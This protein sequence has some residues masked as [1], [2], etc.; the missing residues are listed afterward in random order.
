MCSP[1][2]TGWRRL[3]IA[4]VGG[5]IGGLA[6]AISLRRAG[7]SVTIYERADFAGEKG[8]SV[9]C[10]ANGT[11]WLEEWGVDVQKGDPVHLKK[12][13]SR[14]KKRLN[15]EVVGSVWDL[16]SWEAGELRGDTGDEVGVLDSNPLRRSSGPVVRLCLVDY[17][18]IGRLTTACLPTP[19]PTGNLPPSLAS[20]PSSPQPDEQTRY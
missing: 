6:A 3:N 16:V 13:I 2:S 8:A 14:A 17:L 9:S 20:S 5:G 7:H 18:A 11:R 10:A 15:E 4:I 12:L 1:S 19:T